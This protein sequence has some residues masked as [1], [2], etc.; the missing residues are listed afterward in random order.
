MRRDDYKNSMPEEIACEFLNIYERDGRGAISV[1]N[2]VMHV[3]AHPGLT[4]ML[5]AL[6]RELILL[7]QTIRTEGQA[8]PPVAGKTLDQ[9]EK[10]AVVWA[11]A[12]NN[13]NREAAAKELGMGERT[14]YRKLH[15]WRMVGKKKCLRPLQ[16][17][18]EA[19][20]EKYGPIHPGNVGKERYSSQP[21]MAS[22][23][24]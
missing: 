3:Q 12:R 7:I 6:R 18:C 24:A 21:P 4:D 17:D 16:C 22:R 10:D 2:E 14:L 1:G 11:L 19:C 23:F 15:D 20:I 8:G 9:I 13:G 5:P